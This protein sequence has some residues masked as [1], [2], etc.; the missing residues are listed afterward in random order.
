MPELSD[1]ILGILA[2][3]PQKPG[4]YIMRDAGGV[5]IYV[6]K[7]I[8]LK[9]RVRSYFQERA[10][11]DRKTRKLVTHITDLEWIVVGSE[12]EALILEMNLIKKH[13]P[14]FNVRLKDDKRY[15]YIKV[16][17]NDPFPKVT[18]TRI[19]VKDGSRYFGP[20][21]SVWA[22]HQT[23]DLLRKIFPYLTCDRE[24]TG[25]DAR[26]C[27]YFDIKL[28]SGPCIGAINQAGYKQL[29]TDLCSFLDGHTDP[30]VSRLQREMKAAS[31][32]L[33]FERAAVIRDQLNAIERV[34][35]K[36]KVITGDQ[37]DS[38][39]L[40]LARADGEACVQI[41]FIRNG[42]L[43]GREY[44]ILEGTEEISDNEV[45]G[46]FIKQFYSEAATIPDRVLLP[47]EV[48]E[49][50]IIQQWLNTKRGGEK[51]QMFVPKS[52]SNS[53]D[54]VKMATENAVETLQALR[55]QWEADKNKQTQALAELQNALQLVEPPNRIECYDISNTQGTSSVGSMVVFEQGTPS[56]GMYRHFNI[57]TVV[58]PDDFAS[59]EEVLTRRF[60]RWQAAQE[61]QLVGAKLDPSFA[62]LP[63]LLMVDGGKGQLGRAVKVLESFGLSERVPLVGLAKQQEELFRPHIERSI[64][65]PR[66]SQGLYLIQRVRDE[67]HRFA[68]TAHR[69]ARGKVGIASR[70]DAIPGVGP[71]RRRAL[72]EKFGDINSI[73]QAPLEELTK[74]PGITEDIALAL[75]SGLD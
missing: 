48:E 27:L 55:S 6:G 15:P 74:I 7:A 72:L 39:V 45:V 17:L 21:T 12:L 37:S 34:V 43:M 73:R 5:V 57:K 22:V 42:K 54:L 29:I 65:L 23:L 4:C 2:T 10:D 19:M 14:H 66:H 53:D 11:M 13:R 59:M 31:K 8:N 25:L 18:V 40:A 62:V 60:K 35:E 49:A 58:G 1:H 52:G 70:L 63:D 56:K 9:N 69:K 28:C 71:K 16:H 75:Q 50:Q 30:I 36:Q 46:E 20:Y 41:F 68:V 61:K 24:I 38:D 3:L 67:A 47:N 51:M 33:N 32:S 44:F 64:I 26:P